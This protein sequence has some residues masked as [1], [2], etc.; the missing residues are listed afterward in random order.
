[1]TASTPRVRRRSGEVRALLLDAAGEL[2]AAQDYESVSTRLIAAKAQVTHATLF[3]HF[4]TKDELYVAAVFNPFREFV[5]QYIRRWTEGGHGRTSSFEDTLAF[6]EGL[7]GLFRENRRL[8]AAMVGP[9]STTLSPH[10]ARFLDETLAQLAAEVDKEVAETGGRTIDVG[11]AVRF[12]FA[13]I[14]GTAVLDDV[15]YPAEG[16][17]PAPELLSRELAGYILRGSSIEG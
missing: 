5:G 16:A 4:R 13:L 10:V 3:R 12:S 2:F 14:Y 7:Y 11:H 8:L 1:M 15:L 9:S 6:V 17:R